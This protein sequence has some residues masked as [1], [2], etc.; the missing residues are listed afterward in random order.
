MGPED[1]TGI[2]IERIRRQG[3]NRCNVMVD[4]DGGLRVLIAYKPTPAR[5][6][7]AVMIGSFTN[8]TPVSAIRRAFE[9]KL[10]W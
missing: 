8:K 10:P 7:D 5:F 1:L 9:E 6:A 3:G 4:S 2:T